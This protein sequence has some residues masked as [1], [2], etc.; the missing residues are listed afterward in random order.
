MRMTVVSLRRYPVKSMGGEALESADLDT[1]G[2]VGDRRYAVVDA[3]G[4]LAS[5]KN[6]RRFR[7]RDAIFDYTARSTDD[8]DVLVSNGRHEWRVGEQGLVE[9]LAN[10]MNARVTLA[11]DRTATHQDEAAVSLVSTATLDWC[12]AR[13]GID[14]DPRRLR[15]NLVVAADEPFAEETWEGRELAIGDG[16]RLRVTRR[17]PRCR[18]IDVDQDG[19][20]AE[21][22]WLRSLGAERDTRIG[23][24]AE[25]VEPGTVRTG[26]LISPC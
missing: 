3:A 10:A 12:A 22:R 9:D 23:V 20:V 17:I 1:H 13:W 26:D 6:T 4:F 24:Y 7:R 21:G 11:A 2:L 15:T 16:V 25:V 18:M 19:V 5:G 8:H 14:A